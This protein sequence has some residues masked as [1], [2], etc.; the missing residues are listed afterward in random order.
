LTLAACAAAAATSAGGSAAQTLR[1]YVNEALERLGRLE[2]FEQAS[3]C[4]TRYIAESTGPT[5]V[6]LVS[7]INFRLEASYGFAT[8]KV[9][10]MIA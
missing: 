9:L 4:V 5:R 2:E 8:R 10:I 1:Y 7:S 6:P 3:V